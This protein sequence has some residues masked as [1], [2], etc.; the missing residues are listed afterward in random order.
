MRTLTSHLSDLTVS[1]RSRKKVDRTPVLLMKRRRS[2]RSTSASS[3]ALITVWFEIR[4]W[5]ES[6]KLHC[7]VVTR[8]LRLLVYE[9]KALKRKTNF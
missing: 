3:S 9:M 7:E 4:T 5:L 1:R 2:S 8:T 6:S